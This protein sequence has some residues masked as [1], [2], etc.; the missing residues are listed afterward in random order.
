MDGKE[1]VGLENYEGFTGG[2]HQYENVFLLMG[3]H[4]VEAFV[5]AHEAVLRGGIFWSEKKQKVLTGSFE[6]VVKTDYLNF[7]LKIKLLKNGTKQSS[8]E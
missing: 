3:K 7:I 5:L 1:T 4:S 2:F 6:R 8:S